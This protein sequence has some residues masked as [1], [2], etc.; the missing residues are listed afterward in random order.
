MIVPA[1]RTAWTLPWAAFPGSLYADAMRYL[2]RLGGSD[3]LEELPFR[4]VRPLTLQHREYQ[5]RQF[6]SA[7]VMRG[8]DAS[9]LTSLAD[10]VAVDTFKDGLRYLLERR[11]GKS[12]ATTVHLATSLKAIARH[13]VRADAHHLER[14]AAV[15]SRLD[16]PKRGLNAKNRSRLRALDDPKTAS[17]LV[18]LPAK[19]MTLADRERHALRAAR[20]AQTAVALEVLLMAPIRSAISARSMSSGI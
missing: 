2:D 17:A 7:L 10:L 4:P 8:R 14:M 13:H 12:T 18:Q 6:A 3:P 5:I 1:R 9:T 15:I 16:A 19:L 11:G 20:L